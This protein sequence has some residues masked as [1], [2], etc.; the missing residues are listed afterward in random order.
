MFDPSQSSIKHQGPY[1]DP[2]RMTVVVMAVARRNAHSKNLSHTSATCFHSTSVTSRRSCSVS[3][4]SLRS[5]VWFTLLSTRK[6]CASKLSAMDNNLQYAVSKQSN[7][8]MRFAVLTAVSVEIT[9]SLD[10]MLCSLVT[11]EF[12][13]WNL[14]SPDIQGQ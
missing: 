12:L 9:L 6:N 14:V 2:Q 8:I 11:G 1:G 10:A 3:R 7:L 13:Q 4:S 5:M